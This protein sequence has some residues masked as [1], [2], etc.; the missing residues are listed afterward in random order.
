MLSKADL[1]SGK[2][3]KKH[4]K[5]TELQ[6]QAGCRSCHRERPNAPAAK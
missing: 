4:P 3:S 1:D 6:V 2:M 5:L